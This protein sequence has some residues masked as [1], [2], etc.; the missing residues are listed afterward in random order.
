MMPNVGNRQYVSNSNGLMGQSMVGYSGTAD[1]G[2]GSCSLI[3]GYNSHLPT[4]HH[5]SYNLNLRLRPHDFS[6]NNIT[7]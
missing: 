3:G 1:N 7:L 4:A 2:Y 5:S 6:I